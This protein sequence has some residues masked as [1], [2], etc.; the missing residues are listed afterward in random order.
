[1]TQF[2]VDHTK[3]FERSARNEVEKAISRGTIRVQNTAIDLVTRFSGPTKSLPDAVPSR[4]GEPPHV[5]TGTLARSI[6]QETFERVNEFIGRV[7]TNLK[8]GL[9]LEIGTANMEMRPYFRPSLELNRRPILR[10]IQKA[11][12]RFGKGMA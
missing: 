7:G 1:M 5:R 12:G 6:D 4:P 2:F 9:W 3:E 11:G 8:Y 10:E